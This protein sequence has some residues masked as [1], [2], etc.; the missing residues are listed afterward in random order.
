MEG[1]LGTLQKALYET[2]K[3]GFEKFTRKRQGIEGYLGHERGLKGVDSFKEAIRAYVTGAVQ[4]SKR[5][6]HHS[7]DSALRKDLR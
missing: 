5:L 1:E 3:V 4:A 7:M 2:T 6:D